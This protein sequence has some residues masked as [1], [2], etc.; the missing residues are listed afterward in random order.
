MTFSVSVFD[1]CDVCRK[2]FRFNLKDF[3]CCGQKVCPS[4]FYVTIWCR[5]CE[6]F[7]HEFK[8]K[9][10]KGCIK[11]IVRRRGVPEEYFDS[12]VIENDLNEA[13]H[14]AFHER[15]CKIIEDELDEVIHPAPKQKESV[16]NEEKDA[17][18]PPQ[19]RHGSLYNRIYAFIDKNNPFSGESLTTEKP[20]PKKR[21][22]DINNN[23]DCI[24]IEDDKSDERIAPVP[25][26]KTSILKKS[27]RVTFSSDSLSVC[28]FLKETDEP[29]RP[30]P[31]RNR[32]KVSADI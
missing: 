23:D 16:F 4:C 14:E 20:S 13:F 1:N 25:K 32:R 18:S 7:H 29:M 24:I 21:K 10:A 31:K 17:S 8:K 6:L 5:K 2:V 30:Y 28:S 19:S 12:P 3:G 9:N 15:H 11:P 27:K 22:I 26:P